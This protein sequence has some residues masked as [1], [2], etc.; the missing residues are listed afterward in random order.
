ME[1]RN[2]T[3]SEEAILKVI[4]EGYGP[5]NSISDVF[6]SKTDEAVIF[7]KLPDGCSKLMAN[8]TNLAAWRADGSIASDE[9][10]RKNWLQLK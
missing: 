9:D 7:V 8:L 10:L 5:Q 2:L 1:R 3:A 6:F 4:Q